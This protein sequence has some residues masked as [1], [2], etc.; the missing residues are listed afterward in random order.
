MYFPLPLGLGL[1]RDIQWLRLRTND[2]LVYELAELYI[3][4]MTSETPNLLNPRI[5]EQIAEL[6][7]PTYP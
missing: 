2:L 3:E 1:V 5:A 4:L 6:S 7:F